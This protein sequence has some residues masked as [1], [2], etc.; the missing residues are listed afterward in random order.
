MGE[1]SGRAVSKTP[2]RHLKQGAY[3]FD[4]P[5]RDM[6]LR[7][8]LSSG[9]RIHEVAAQVGVSAETVRLYHRENIEGF[10]DQFEEVRGIFRDS[11]EAE[12]HRRAM[13]GVP[14]PVIGGKD[15]D[16]V[17]TTVQRYS[18]RLLELL[19]KRHIKEYREKQQMDLNVTGGVML[20]PARMQS[21]DDWEGQYQELELPREQEE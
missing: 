16:R 11:I 14:E 13:E 21:T 5:T 17:V 19:A 20:A 4:E 9:G 2:I 7:L 15:R 10:G 6:F 3:K 12:I 18:D 1:E 8:Y